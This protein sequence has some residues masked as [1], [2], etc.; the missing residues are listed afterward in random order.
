[1][2]A[3]MCSNQH[4][5]AIVHAYV[6]PEWSRDQPTLA[7]RKATAKILFDENVRSL[8]SR[9]PNHPHN[10]KFTMVSPRRE[11]TVVELL[12]L[13]DCYEYQAC[14]T[15]D[16]KETAAAKICREYREHLI[17]RLPGYDA[18]PWGVE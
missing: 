16:F 6:P 10:Y 3:W 7:D 18:A 13:I 17:G 15:N 9:Y 8:K 14:E 11:Y 2:S 12:K 4:I 5:S 1:M